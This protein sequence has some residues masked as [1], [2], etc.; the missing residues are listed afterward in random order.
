[1]D[2]EESL[3]GQRRVKSPLSQ[4]EKIVIGF[5]LGFIG[6]LLFIMMISVLSIS[7]SMPESTPTSAT[8]SD[9]HTKPMLDRSTLPQCQPPVSPSRVCVICFEFV[10]LS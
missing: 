10:Q 7:S 4:T 8:S 6:V 3:V 1:M 5:C 9:S 2:D